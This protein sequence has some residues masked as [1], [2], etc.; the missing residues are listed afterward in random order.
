MEKQL[1]PRENDTN[2]GR[3]QPRF[4]EVSVRKYVIESSVEAENELEFPR[5]VDSVRKRLEIV[6]L[7]IFEW[8]IIFDCV[9]SRELP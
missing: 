2:F 1:C 3:S 4:S 5:E 8:R 7:N 9:V 6:S